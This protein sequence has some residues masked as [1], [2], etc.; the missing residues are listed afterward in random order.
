MNIICNYEFMTTKLTYI[1]IQ[2]K[3]SII[4]FDKT[5][6]PLHYYWFNFCGF[7]IVCNIFIYVDAIWKKK[8]LFVFFLLI[9]TNIQWYPLSIINKC[10]VYSKNNYYILLLQKY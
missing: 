1:R 7:I 10:S 3:K 9:F 2:L 8:K 5:I 4:I 6:T